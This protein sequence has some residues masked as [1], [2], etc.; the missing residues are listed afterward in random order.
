[1]KIAHI[2]FLFLVI[3]N[4]FLFG[5]A[6][7]YAEDT[8][9]SVFITLEEDNFDIVFD[10]DGVLQ[11]SSLNQAAVYPVGGSVPAL[12]SI[13]INYAIDAGKRYEKFRYSLN[14]RLICCGV[15]KILRPTSMVT[16]ADIDYIIDD[17]DGY[18]CGNYPV[19]NCE[20]VSTSM[21][22]GM[23]MLHFMLCPFIY[24]AN[25]EK[26]YFV[27]SVSMEISLV[28]DIREEYVGAISTYSSLEYYN[29]VSL[30]DRDFISSLVINPEE[31][32]GMV[33][34]MFDKYPVL[35]GHENAE[36]IIV[37]ANRLR[38]A[39]EPLIEW[40]RE[41]GIR[42]RVVTELDLIL[43]YGKKY[44]NDPP[45]CLKEYLYQL[46]RTGLRYVLLGG[47]D[48]IVPVRKCFGYTWIPANPEEVPIPTDLYY[49]CFGANFDWDLN[50]NEIYGEPADSV[51]LVPSI[52]VTRV[53]VKTTE[54][55]SAFVKKILSYEQSPVWNNNILM[56]GRRLLTDHVNSDD[57]EIQSNLMYSQYIEPYWTGD[58]VRMYDSYS[59]VP[60]G[61]HRFTPY[62][63]QK[64]MEK[65]YNFFSIYTHGNQTGWACE[66]GSEYNSERAFSQKN[67]G[68]TIVTTSACL[69]N[70]F[71]VFV[72]ADADTCLSEAFIKNPDNGVVAYWGAS[73]VGFGR[74]SSKVLGISL[75]YEGE[76]YKNLFSDKVV[77]KS[78]GEVAAAA[79]SALVGESNIIQLGN[80][81]VVEGCQ[82]RWLQYAL[83]PIGDPEMPVFTSEPKEFCNASLIDKSTELVIETGVD[84]CRVCL[85][86]SDDNGKSFYRVFKNV[87]RVAITEYPDKVKL[88]ITKPGYIPLRYSYEAISKVSDDG[89]KSYSLYMDEMAAD[90]QENVSAINMCEYDSAT[91]IVEISTTISNNRES[92][93]LIITDQFGSFVK[94]VPVPEKTHRSVCD[95]SGMPNGVCVVSLLVNGKSEDFKRFVKK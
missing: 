53:P 78:F 5:P 16:G 46:A 59:D 41:K 72:G 45:L 89:I 7:L 35:G 86:S 56:G 88:C 31:A 57:A 21:M 50:G 65:G 70:A 62:I 2:T 73:R 91:N 81:I 90:A 51:N 44:K 58:I 61:I 75:T 24:D 1:M 64:E 69:T 80:S 15:R 17:G 26:L 39:F 28:D 92:A 37:T 60:I 23:S 66:N 48:T 76:F 94:H 33:G 42:A 38:D 63:I 27:D 3:S 34:P 85:M 43:E 55:V 18:D 77:S 67:A 87:D 12:P 6:D 49:G 29:P 79:K 68:H 25:D 32:D 10:S 4:T 8:A 84:S 19:S 82:Y 83:N 74:T 95:L 14:K 13:S 9:K 93:E 52:Y 22:D 36:Y 30:P 11:I 71:D 54:D 20:Y 40:K 47:D